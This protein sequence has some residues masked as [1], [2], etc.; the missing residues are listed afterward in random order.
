MGFDFGMIFYITRQLGISVEIE[1]ITTYADIGA[2]DTTMELDLSQTLLFAGLE[3]R[4]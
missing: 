2:E 4:L 3:A 1:T